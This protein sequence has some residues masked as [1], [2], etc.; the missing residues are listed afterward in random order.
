MV[1]DNYTLILGDC[2]KYLGS[3]S[4]EYINLTVTSPPYDD[5]RT[6]NGTLNWGFDVFKTIANELYRV[7]CDGGVVVWIVNDSTIN[8]GESGT[9]FKQ[10]LY[11]MSIG[12]NLHDTMI[13]EKHNPTPNTG[14]GVRYQ[15]SFEYMFVFV[16]G[17]H[18][19]CHNLITEDRRN[20]CNDKRSYRPIRRQ[21]NKDGDF[22]DVHM[23]TIKDEVPK[24]NIWRY[25]VGM[26]NT[27][28]DKIAFSHPAIFPDQ[29]A[30]DHIL[31]WSNPGDIVLDPFMGSGTTGKMALKNGRKFIGIEVVE[32]YFNIAKERIE[33][34]NETIDY[35]I[36]DDS[37]TTKLW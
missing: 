29:L 7:T 13:Y 25:K 19:R 12:F 21:R 35:S 37:S 16:K 3:I 20:A 2:A 36:N 4:S 24:S 6:Y 28:C 14:N 22:E 27:T 30:T 1:N 34:F 8:G 32:K 17:K 5:L 31:S 23:Y 9:S 11:F 26:Y 18:I 15:Q 33:N 10:A